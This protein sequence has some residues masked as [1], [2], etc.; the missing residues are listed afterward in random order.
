MQWGLETPKKIFSRYFLRS[1]TIWIFSLISRENYRAGRRANGL[2]GCYEIRSLGE[3]FARGPCRM[4]ACAGAT[5]HRASALRKGLG[6][7]ARRRFLDRP[8]QLLSPR[9]RLR[10]TA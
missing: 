2:G 1:E 4:R 8:A 6:Q 7:A 5:S 3:R 9:A 10:L